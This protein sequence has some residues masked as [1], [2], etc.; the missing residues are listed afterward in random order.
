MAAYGWAVLALP[1]AG[2]LRHRLPDRAHAAGR[3]A[4]L[5]V[6]DGVIARAGGFPGRA[7]R[8]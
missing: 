1:A 6:C 5:S 3:W 4:P 8:L 2:D 7:A